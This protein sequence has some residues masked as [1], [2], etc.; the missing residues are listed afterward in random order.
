MPRSLP[1]L[2]HSD[3]PIGQ[4]LVI[5]TREWFDFFSRLMAVLLN[6]LAVTGT[7]VFSG[8]TTATVT[9]ATAEADANYSVWYA[10]EENRTYWTTSKTAAGFTAN[11]SS[12][13]SATV[14]WQLVRS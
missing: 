13:S 14:R 6:R 10:A 7:A 3:V 12:A 5:A 11:A 9:F 8:G 1:G 2:P 4:P